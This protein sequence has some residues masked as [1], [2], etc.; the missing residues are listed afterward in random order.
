MVFL[1]DPYPETA[2]FWNYDI[3]KCFQLVFHYQLHWITKNILLA[4]NLPSLTIDESSILARKIVNYFGLKFICK[5]TFG[6][7][8]TFD[9]NAIYCD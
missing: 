3:I 9:M 7:N 5:I 2:K 6:L 8:D 4:L 1:R